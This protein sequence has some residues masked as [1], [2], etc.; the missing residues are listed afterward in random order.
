MAK[1]WVLD[2]DTK[3]T[4]ANMV[5]LERTFKS[6]SGTAP[7]LGFPGFDVREPD[8]PDA[9]D[10]PAAAPAPRNPLEFRVLDIM[11]REV[12]AERA[13]A[14]ATV[15]ALEDVRSIVDVVVYVWDAGRERW[16]ML[17]LGETQALWAHRRRG[18]RRRGAPSGSR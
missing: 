8:A 15:A 12:I 6:A 4:G 7:G 5:P 14:R 1:V 3:G 16:R 17:T 2:T 11:T 9:P 10:E 13:D 18:P